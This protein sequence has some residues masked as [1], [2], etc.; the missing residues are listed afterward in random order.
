ME[1]WRKLLLQPA[2]VGRARNINVSGRSATSL[3]KVHC[4]DVCK[5]PVEDVC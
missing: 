2:R 3:F 1:L 5:S 4:P